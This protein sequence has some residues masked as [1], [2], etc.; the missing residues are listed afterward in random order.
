MDQILNQNFLYQFFWMLTLSKRPYSRPRA[1][2]PNL[3]VP[4]KCLEDDEL[5]SNTITFKTFQVDPP[6][7]TGIT[8][9]PL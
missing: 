9:V 1:P 7:R 6:H 8:E 2:R 5:L 4:G 3:R